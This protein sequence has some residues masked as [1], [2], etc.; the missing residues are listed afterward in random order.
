[1]SCVS[2]FGGETGVQVVTT[3]KTNTEA[4]T[5]LATDV[6]TRNG[7]T[8]L[9]RTTLTKSGV[10]QIRIQKFYHSGVF[11][12]RYM[13]T[14]DS[15]GFKTEA[16]IPYS[17]SFEFGRSNEVRSAIIETKDSILDI[18]C[19]T[20]GVFYP[21]EAIRIQQANDA[22]GAMSDAEHARTPAEVVKKMEEAATKIK[23]KYTNTIR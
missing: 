9:V 22:L 19:F 4:E 23:E 3:V 13:A 14:K 16:G 2:V 5:I 18:F 6:C 8:N 1:L 15:S 11:V 7:Q 21:A 10:V 17:V 20:N 12:G